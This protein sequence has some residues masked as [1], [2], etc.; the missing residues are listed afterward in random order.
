MPAMGQLN[1]VS[2]L[3]LLNRLGMAH[4]HGHLVLENENG[5]LRFVFQQGRLGATQSTWLQETPERWLLAEDLL[6]PRELCL[7]G[8]HIGQ[9]LTEN[10]SAGKVDASRV[11]Q[12]LE[13]AA[14]QTLAR[15]MAW[16]QGN[17]VWKDTPPEVR[18]PLVVKDNWSLFLSAARALPED[19]FK[20]R[21]EAFWT[22]PWKQ[23]LHSI[24]SETLPWHAEELEAVHRLKLCE[25]PAKAVPHADA[26]GLYARVAFVLWQAEIWMPT[27]ASPC[28][29]VSKTPGE[30][31]M[32][33]TPEQP[34]ASAPEKPA[35][36]SAEKDAFEKPGENSAVDAEW[37]AKLK[38]MQKAWEG[39]DA[40]SILGVAQEA[41]PSEIKRAY[42]TW[43][44]QT[45][46]DKLPPGV[47][48][49]TKKVAA[50]VFAQLGEAYRCLSNEE[51]RTALLLKL[52]GGNSEEHL[53]LE[54]LLAS[55]SLF[56]KAA[57]M[58]ASRRFLEALP[59][60]QEAL[61]L[62][63]EA[64][65]CWAYL[66]YAKR[67][68]PGHG[69]QAALGDLEKAKQQNPAFPDTYYFLGRLAKLRKETALAKQFFEQCLSL[70]PHHVEAHQELRLLR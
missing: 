34:A 19:F 37:Q 62:N 65:E 9:W 5:C 4:A 69:E 58:V 33:A 64:A 63:P 61:K 30:K 20:Q 22:L 14:K 16:N 49:N 54:T 11:L 12:C 3:G 43:V 26:L 52:S 67:F 38:A 57:R 39:K 55:E 36:H 45:H 53:G 56:K 46:P 25:T 47:S 70:A 41:Q 7:P 6:E 28:V 29:C 23:V 10:I 66:G 8:F 42:F 44:R 31:P 27:S 50:D 17:Y 32:D 15:A 24:N 60:L 21:L 2:P 40:F 13:C 68:I 51:E 59:V 18:V 35:D 48:E 1:G